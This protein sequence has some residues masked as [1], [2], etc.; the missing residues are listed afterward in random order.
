MIVVHQDLLGEEH[1][2]PESLGIAVV[3]QMSRIIGDHP[4]FG[5]LGPQLFDQR[6]LV[7]AYQEN[8]DKSLMGELVP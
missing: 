6:T 3:P 2:T 8:P 5:N 7:P 4:I 1:I